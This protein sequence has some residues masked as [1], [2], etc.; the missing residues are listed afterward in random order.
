MDWDPLPPAPPLKLLDPPLRTAK[1]EVG[2]KVVVCGRAVR[3]WDDEMKV[4][5]R[6][7]EGVV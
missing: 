6:A 5:N 7:E 2:G 1:A 4:K 3:W